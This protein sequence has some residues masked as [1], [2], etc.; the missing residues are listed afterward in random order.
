[1][2][3]RTYERWESELP[4]ASQGA[5]WGV[6][7]SSPALSPQAGSRSHYP[8]SHSGLTGYFQPALTAVTSLH[9]TTSKYLTYHPLPCIPSPRKEPCKQRENK[10]GGRK[11]QLLLQTCDLLSALR[12]GLPRE[13]GEVGECAARSCAPRR[14]GHRSPPQ[15]IPAARSEL[16][17]SSEN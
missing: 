11:R 12:T 2:P 14:A 1:M 10:R 16:T 7:R 17:L 15:D 3:P 6:C 4:L 9:H 8:L 5:A 13:A